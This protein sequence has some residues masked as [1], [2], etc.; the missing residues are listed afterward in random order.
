MALARWLHADG[1]VLVVIIS[2]DS[3]ISFKGKSLDMTKSLVLGNL[4]GLLRSVTSF[5]FWM[6]YWLYNPTSNHRD[7]FKLPLASSV[8]QSHTITYKLAVLNQEI[9]C[10]RIAHWR[11][12][13]ILSKSSGERCLFNDGS[14]IS[15]RAEIT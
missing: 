5:F 10:Q 9:A 7:V 15:V 2:S 6:V 1:Y 3:F 13:T 12:L 8:Q 11:N 4:E 14:S